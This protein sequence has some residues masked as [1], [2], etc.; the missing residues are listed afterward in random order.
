MLPSKI[1]NGI[2]ATLNEV[3]KE[4]QDL[5]KRERRL[6]TK[7]S[8]NYAAFLILTE[9]GHS[10]NIEYQDLYEFWAEE[11]DAPESDFREELDAALGSGMIEVCGASRYAPTAKY[12]LTNRF[13][14][15]YYLGEDVD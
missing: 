7:A 15:N 9:A 11:V 5:K 2:Q 10:D 14:E 8:L 12:S 1:A 3:A 6:K 13:C 4:I